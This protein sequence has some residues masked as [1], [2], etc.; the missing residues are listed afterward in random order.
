MALSN[1][2]LVTSTL[3]HSTC[4]RKPTE[5]H[6]TLPPVRNTES[7][8]RWGWLGLACETIISAIQQ[9][10]K[11]LNWIRCK[12]SHSFSNNV[13]ER[14]TLNYPPSSSFFR[15]HAC[16][17]S[18]VWRESGYARLRKVPL[19]QI[20]FQLMT[21]ASCMRTLIIYSCKELQ[22]LTVLPTRHSTYHN[23]LSVRSSSLAVD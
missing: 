4:T 11:T 10:C 3:M 21:L 23:K 5:S 17:E 8:P 16:Q 22:H 19:Q 2:S 20:L 1:I 7:D 15:N 9:V 12:L 14:S 18:V 6:Q 13:P